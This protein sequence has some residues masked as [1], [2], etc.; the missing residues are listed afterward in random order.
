MKYYILYIIGSLSH[1]IESIWRH[2]IAS[3]PH[4]LPMSDRVQSYVRE[5]MRDVLL[6]LST[7]N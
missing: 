1:D 3:M 4:S 2:S 5:Q 6:L 7:A